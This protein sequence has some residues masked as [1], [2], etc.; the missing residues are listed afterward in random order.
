MSF[1]TRRECGNV[2]CA[3]NQATIDE[4]RRAEVDA[5]YLSDMRTETCGFAERCQVCGSI[6]GEDCTC[7]QEVL[8]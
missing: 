1:C 5:F 7:H 6:L 4:A 2:T 8:P 3:R